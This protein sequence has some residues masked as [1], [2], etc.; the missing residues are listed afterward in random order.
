MKKFAFFEENPTQPMDLVADWKDA[1]GIKTQEI[2]IYEIIFQLSVMKSTEKFVA[3][4]FLEIK[5][6][7]VEHL[8]P[9]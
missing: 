7:V 8:N 1:K 5:F 4:F 6:E 3:R 2:I 9:C